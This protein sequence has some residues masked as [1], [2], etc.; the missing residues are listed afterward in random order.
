MVTKQ[1]NKHFIGYLRRERRLSKEEEE[2]RPAWLSG[3]GVSLLVSP[4]SLS[5]ELPLLL[6]SNSS[7]E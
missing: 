1:R 5:K 7:R 4:Q 3:V 6:Q 2:N